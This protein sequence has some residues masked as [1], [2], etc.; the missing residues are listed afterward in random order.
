WWR[1]FLFQVTQRPL[2]S[3]GGPFAKGLNGRSQ[4]G[5]TLRSAAGDST[6]SRSRF[7][8]RSTVLDTDMVSVCGTGGATGP[9]ASRLTPQATDSTRTART[10]TCAA[11]LSDLLMFATMS[12]PQLFPNW[13]PINLSP[14]HKSPKDDP[15]RYRALSGVRRLR[16]GRSTSASLRCSA[17]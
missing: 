14:A 16:C 9:R 17:E 15:D 3:W 10:I 11:A 1:T 4:P 8:V 12:M 13:R 6:G 2:K 7:N 5:R